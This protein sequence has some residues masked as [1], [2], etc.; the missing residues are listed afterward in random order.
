MEPCAFILRA[1]DLRQ[2]GCGPRKA[3]SLSRTEQEE[4]RTERCGSGRPYLRA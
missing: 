3:Q 1:G 2:K 4:S